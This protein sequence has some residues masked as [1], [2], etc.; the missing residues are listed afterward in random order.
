[1]SS[2]VILSK[3][4]SGYADRVVRDLQISSPPVSSDQV[5]EYFGIQLSFFSSIDMVSRIGTDGVELDIPA[6]LWTK[7]NTG[8]IFVNSDNSRSRQR[9]SIFHECA[10][11]DIPWHRHSS[12]VCKDTDLAISYRFE[13]E[14]EAH[15]YAARVM[16]PQHLFVPDTRALPSNIESIKT[17]SVRYSASFE[18]TAI[19][20][21][22][23]HSG[24]CAV[25]Y[26]M[27][28]D[29][30]S[31]EFP[32]VV[33]YAV[34]SRDFHRF[35]KP[36]DKVRECELISEVFSE[37]TELEGEIPAYVFGSKKGHSYVATL[38]PH[39]PDNVCAFVYMEDPW[40]KIF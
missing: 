17:L 40:Y 5:L 25:I 39:G 26:L 16:F 35:I 9:F 21:T 27:R 38:K 14:K 12:Y 3:S 31:N 15:E 20:Y 29:N 10:H 22:Q 2:N 6:F 7:S 18:A 23:V 28:N 37:R 19:R 24:Q 11:F 8:H 13:D 33:R 1:M 36:G 32:Y 4:P 30:G 34:K